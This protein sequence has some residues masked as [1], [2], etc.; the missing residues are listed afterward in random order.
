MEWIGF[1]FAGDATSIDRD[2]IY[3]AVETCV[4]DV[5][6]AIRLALLKSCIAALH[7][8]AHYDILQHNHAPQLSLGVT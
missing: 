6:Q 8:C 7:C 5:Q 4:D 2:E 1:G 3:P